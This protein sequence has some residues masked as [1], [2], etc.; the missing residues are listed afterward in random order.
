MPILTEIPFE[1]NL[2]AL[3]KRAH[4]PRDSTNAAEFARL[5]QEAVVV[6]RPKA[7]YR[8]AFIENKGEATVII[9]GIVFESRMLRNQL[10][11]VERVFPFVVT[12]G[13]ELDQAA[14]P[15]VDLLKRYWWDLIKGELLGVA[16]QHL[17]EHLDS[18]FRLPKT[19]AM[20]PG[21]GD[22]AVWPIEQQRVLFTLLE[23]IPEQ[24]GVELTDTYLMIPNKTVSGIC[25]PTEVDFRSCQVCRRIVCPNRAAPFDQVLW[26][27]IQDQ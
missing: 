13:Q 7:G 10:E 23:D 16:R 8:E 21:S 9:E 26:D 11:H 3:L 25:F 22:A 2:P 14:L 19:S 15:E 20:H 12:C 5:V 1:L 24:I 17:A 27:S 4:V 6:G 18:R